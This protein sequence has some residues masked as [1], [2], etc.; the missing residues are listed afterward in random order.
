MLVSDTDNWWSLWAVRDVKTWHLASFLLLVALVALV[1]LLTVLLFPRAPEP[2][3]SIDLRAHYYESSKIF[4]RAHAAAWALA[5]LC[6]LT[7]YPNKG[8]DPFVIIP[9]AIVILSLIVGQTKRPLYHAAFSLI[10]LVAVT[11][12]LVTQGA[13]IE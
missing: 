8:F 12:I 9:A 5:S 7:L 11:F 6:K 13:R 3:E 4:L 1:F 2:G 10:T